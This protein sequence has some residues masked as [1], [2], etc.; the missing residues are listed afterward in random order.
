MVKNPPAMWETWVQSLGWEDLQ[1]EGKATHSSILCLENLM[2]RGAWQ[3][4]VQGSQRLGHDWATKHSTARRDS[5]GK[6]GCCCSVAQLCPTLCDPM[7]CSTPGFPVPHYLLEFAQTQVHWVGDAISSSVIPFSSCL[8]SFPT[9]G[10]FQI[11]QL[12]ASGGQSIGGSALTSILLMNIQG[13]FLLGLT[14]LILQSKELSR[15]F[16][17]NTVWRH[18]FFGT[19]PSLW[20]NSHVCT[21]LLRKL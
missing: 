8:Q 17:S 15:I 9:S 5:Y 14:G 1:E 11:S 16:S 3:A 13:W 18:Q 6:P 4:T 20:F 2:D 21:W 10:S 12:F 19:Q 7:D